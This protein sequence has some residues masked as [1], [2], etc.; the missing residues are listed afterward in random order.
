MT[1]INISI[2]LS[3]YLHRARGAICSCCCCTEA[4]VPAMKLWEREWPLWRFGATSNQ[5]WS[6][7]LFAVHCLLEF[8]HVYAVFWDFC[9]EQMSCKS[10]LTL[11]GVIISLD[12]FQI[13]CEA[14]VNT[15]SPL[16][17]GSTTACSKTSVNIP[18]S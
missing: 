5:C 12:A 3:I 18:H 1:S 13:F 2:Y 4:S 17:N 14:R 9:L 8:V 16:S 15:R 7:T 11:Q 10:F 6:F